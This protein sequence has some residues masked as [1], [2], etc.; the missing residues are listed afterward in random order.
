MDEDKKLYGSDLFCVIFTFFTFACF[1]KGIRAESIE[2]LR[3]YGRAFLIFA[4]LATC[5]G[6][7]WYII[8]TKKANRNPKA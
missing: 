6:F 5:T 8:Y 2:I 4:P 7:I 3:F 1:Y